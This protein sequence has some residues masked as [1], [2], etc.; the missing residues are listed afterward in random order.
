MRP[1]QNA[2]MLGSR[3]VVLQ[4]FVLLGGGGGRGLGGLV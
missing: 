1:P 4:W 3:W 2:K